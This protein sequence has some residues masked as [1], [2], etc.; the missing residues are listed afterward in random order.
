MV[1]IIYM[2][3]Y[4]S[5]SSNSIHN[6]TLGFATPLN[7]IFCTIISANHLSFFTTIR[8]IIPSGDY[9]L[10]GDGAICAQRLQ[11][12]AAPMDLPRFGYYFIS[13]VV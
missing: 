3:P 8:R 12:Q 1:Y 5:G 11:L 13:L 4:I 7:P 6:N 10:R 9:A 2:V